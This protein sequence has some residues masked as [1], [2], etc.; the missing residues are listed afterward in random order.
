M[1]RRPRPSA[2][3]LL[4]TPLLALAGCAGIFQRARPAVAEAY[5]AT[6]PVPAGQL[7]VGSAERVITPAV[8]CYM[9]GFDIGRTSTGVLSPL[10]VRALVVEGGGRRVALV[11]IDNLGLLREDVDWIK[12]GLG[13]FAVG[14]VFVGASHT[15][16]GPDMIGL[17]GFYLMTSG[18]DRAYLALL[19]EQV[20]AAVAE[21]RAGA[22]PAAF[23][24]GEALLPPRGLVKNSNR[25]EVFDRRVTVLQARA[26]ADGR[27]VGTL[28]HLACHPEVLPRRN[29][30]L[31][32][33]YVGELCDEWQR[34]GHGQAV[35]LNGALG[36]MVS[37]AVRPRDL[38]GVQAMGG[39]LCDL[40]E[41]ALA[42]AL[43]SPVAAIEVRRRDV[44]LPVATL[45]FRLGR[46]TTVL[47]RELFSGCARS[48]VGW[49]RLGDF[50]AVAVPGEME[51]ALAAK[52][53]AE[54]GA[55]NLVLFGLCDDELGYLMR[56][57]D[58][59]D[60]EFAYERSMSV[61]VDAGERVRAAITGA[62]SR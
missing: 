61:C 26:L 14:D 1:V 17:W 7:R 20:A 53:R 46:L 3:A 39:S 23:V 48:T 29:T 57:Q 40:A 47:Q 44:Y 31:S 32:A 49:L 58:A 51:P 30:G 25:A 38:A 11:G 16:A 60:P 50:E 41:Q 33:D 55:P 42:A 13:G 9:G 6:T 56:E 22:V 10:K 18:R 59:R 8:G 5:A 12:R 2:A 27:P 28:L 36:A 15:H 4:A 19:R 43:P 34:R 21:A 62:A 35:F 24:R 52:V 54:L 45:G 37:P